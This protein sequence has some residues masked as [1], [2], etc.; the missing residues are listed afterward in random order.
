LKAIAF[1][2]E[3]SHGYAH[4]ALGERP[5]AVGDAHASLAQPVFGRSPLLLNPVTVTKPSRQL[6]R[7]PV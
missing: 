2:H 6:L 3:G 4:A 1:L 5:T 7:A